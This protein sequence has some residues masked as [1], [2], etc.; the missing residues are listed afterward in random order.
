MNTQPPSDDRNTGY[1][2]IAGTLIILAV[3]TATTIVS[4]LSSSQSAETIRNLFIF[5]Y[6]ISLFVMFALIV[7][8]YQITFRGKQYDMNNP[9]IAFII[10]TISG[11]LSSLITGIII[12][13]L[14]SR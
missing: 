12:L 14:Q 9:I 7:K 8:P 4:T 3:L 6:F 5:A 1:R 2:I 10:S 13:I 11:L